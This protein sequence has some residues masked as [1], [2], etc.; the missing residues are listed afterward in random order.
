MYSGFRTILVT[1]AS[2]ILLGAAPN[3]E[4]PHQAPPAQKSSADSD[5]PSSTWAATHGVISP[6]VNTGCLPGK[7][8]R[9]SDLCAQ[10]KAADAAFDGAKWSYWQLILGFVGLFLGAITM[11]AAIAAAIYARRAAIATEDT[12]KIAKQSA[13]ESGFAMAI[14]ARS[15]D[16][17]AAHAEIA[18]DAS[19]KQLRAYVHET[20]LTLRA[21]ADETAVWV[22]VILE[23]KG[24]TPA[25]NLSANASLCLYPDATPPDNE[26][27]GT[28]IPTDAAKQ[29][30]GSGAT[31]AIRDG[32]SCTPNNAADVLAGRWTLLVLGNVTY[33]DVFGETHTTKFRY[34]SHGGYRENG[35]PLLATNFG[36]SFD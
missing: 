35:H 32:V 23:N 18:K 2:L 26:P 15:A 1:A 10:W 28:N 17:A 13:D 6:G 14:A 25:F 12:V 19:K 34:K 27:V 8:D 11:G 20:Q 21:D 22:D 33:E 30:L 4:P 24:A 36:N 3:K 9:R 5:K 31:H 16:A 7:D 29:T